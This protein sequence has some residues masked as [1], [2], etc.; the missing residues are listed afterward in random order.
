MAISREINTMSRLSPALIEGQLHCSHVTHTYEDHAKLICVKISPDILMRRCQSAVRRGSHEHS[1]D[2][3][4]SVVPRGTEVQRAFILSLILTLG[5]LFTGLTFR[6]KLQQSTMHVAELPIKT[7]GRAR[8]DRIA[9]RPMRRA[10][11]FHA[12]PLSSLPPRFGL[13]WMIQRVQTEQSLYRC[14]QRK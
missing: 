10:S 2:F 14:R 5:L 7:R 6:V 3:K 11:A 1:C 9:L 13:I 12:T 8:D 4:E